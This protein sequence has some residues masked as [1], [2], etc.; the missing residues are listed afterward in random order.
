MAIGEAV[1]LDWDAVMRT[2]PCIGGYNR[3]GGASFN[4]R[5][6]VILRLFQKKTICTEGQVPRKYFREFT[7]ELRL[8]SSGTPAAPGPTGD[9]NWSAQPR[10]PLAPTRK[11]AGI[12]DELATNLGQAVQ[13]WYSKMALYSF[14]VT[15]YFYS[16]GPQ[17]FYTR[18]SLSVA[19]SIT[20]LGRSDW[21][22]TCGGQIGEYPPRLY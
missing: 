18:P 19:K 2:T 20:Y 6:K 1:D 13:R 22:Y 4:P 10:P 7:Q 12:I 5:L 17:T 15:V 14:P 8:T 3:S 9:D 21:K 16:P 11:S